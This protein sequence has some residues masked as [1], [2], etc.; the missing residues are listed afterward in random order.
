[1]AS[2]I[3]L[4]VEICQRVKKVTGSPSSFGVTSTGPYGGVIWITGFPSMAE[5]QRAG[6]ALNGDADVV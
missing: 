6:E 3:E 5:L 2:G 1:M 4:G